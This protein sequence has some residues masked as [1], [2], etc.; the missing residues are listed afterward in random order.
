MAQPA[1]PRPLSQVAEEDDVCRVCQQPRTAEEPL[2]HPCKCRGSIKFVHQVSAAPR[3][4]RL[5]G[6]ALRRRVRRRLPL[7]ARQ[8]CLLRWLRQRNRNRCEVC[9]HQF[10]FQPVYRP[11][12]PLQPSVR[13]ILLWLLGAYYHAAASLC[14]LLRRARLLSACVRCSRHLL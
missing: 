5:A 2:Y 13:S 12:A 8:T 3:L 7:L 11:D 14:A 10:D 9:W 1:D 6:N 4:A